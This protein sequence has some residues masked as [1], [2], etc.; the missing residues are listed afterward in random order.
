MQSIP[1]ISFLFR[2]RIVLDRATKSSEVAAVI[3]NA[4]NGM[5]V[6]GAIVLPMHSLFTYTLVAL[7]I[8]LFGPLVG[9]VFTSLYSRVEWTVARRLGG[10]AS[11]DDIY[12]LFAWA[13]L[14]AGFALL[15]YGL[16][17]LTLK[18]SSTKSE[19]FA[20]IPSFILFCCATR[21]YCSNIIVTQH[22]TRTRGAL[23][24]V[25]TLVLFLILIA[26][27]VCLLTLLFRYGMCGSLES[28]FTQ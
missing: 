27:G 10:K 12:C 15:L 20:A 2:P 17:I 8:I 22:F 21:N 23:S 26:G 14:P 6:V 5:F 18:E 24:M 3:V 25:V 9:F 1:G 4:I 28:I 16:I 19:L 13:F 7:Q 11:L